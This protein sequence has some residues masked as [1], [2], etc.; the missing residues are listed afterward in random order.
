MGWSTCGGACDPAFA[1]DE[2][3]QANFMVRTFVLAA[4]A[5]IQHVS[6]FQL[7][8]KFDGK[9]QPWGPAAI[10]NDNLTPKAAYYAYRTMATEL[11]DA[12]YA[13]TGPLHQPGVFADHRFNLA[14]GGS[15]RVLWKLDGRQTVNAGIG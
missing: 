15:V 13:G 12:R 2:D 7:E 4:A 9:Q 8:D 11:R 3:A 14:G 5:G 1:W 6:Y 10:I